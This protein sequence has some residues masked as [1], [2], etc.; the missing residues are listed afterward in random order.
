MRFETTRDVLEWYE[1]QPRALT[2][3]FISGIKWDEVK[4][5]PLDEKFIPVLLHMRDVETLTD[6]YYEELRR[7][8]TGRDP[9]I[10]KFMERWG[11]EE[12]THGDLLNRFVNEAGFDTDKNW[13][14]GVLD[15]VP[16]SYTI[17]NYI[18]SYLTNL[19]GK[20]FTATHMTFGAIHEMSTAQAYRRLVEITDHPILTE[21]LRGIIREESTHTHFYRSVA[22]LELKKSDFA[23]KMA[24]FVIKNFYTPV[25]SGSTPK[26]ESGYAIARLFEGEGGLARIDKNVCQKVQ[27]FP[28]FEGVTKVGETISNVVFEY[29]CPMALMED[30]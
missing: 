29:A 14:D 21:I 15:K 27:K 18:I 3:E 22:R 25:G 1:K 12:L 4:K 16:F 17:N 26:E 24:R 19:V 13:R 28:G 30:A 7:T 10:G 6:V 9:I 8:P 20:K 5:Y 11:V 23:R 2:P